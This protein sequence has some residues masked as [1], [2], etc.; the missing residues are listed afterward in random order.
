MTESGMV[1]SMTGI[2]STAA[3]LGLRGTAGC[4]A[5]NSTAAGIVVR[6]CNI[7]RRFM[8]KESPGLFYCGFWLALHGQVSNRVPGIVNT[9]R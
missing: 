5:L 8:S 3:G 9:N 7:L 4:W 2:S 6:A 1:A